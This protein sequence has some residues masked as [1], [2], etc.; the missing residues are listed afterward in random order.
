V[1]SSDNRLRL[2]SDSEANLRSVIATL[3]QNRV[4]LVESANPEAAQILAVAILQLRMRLNRIAD[5]E[6]KALCQ[7][8]QIQQAH[9]ARKAAERASKDGRLAER[10]SRWPGIVK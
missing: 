10:W 1:A 4:S 3:E 6:L 9:K 2:V 5:S 8:V 7:A